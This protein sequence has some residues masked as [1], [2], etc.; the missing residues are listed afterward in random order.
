MVATFIDSFLAPTFFADSPGLYW[1]PFQLR[2][3]SLPRM[4]NTPSSPSTYF[5]RFSE[6]DGHMFF[7]LNCLKFALPS[8]GS[9]IYFSPR[10]VSTERL[11]DLSP[12]NS[13]DTIFGSVSV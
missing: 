2:Q 12:S 7:S 13:L 9:L 6:D 8:R 4:T 11:K 5:F 3:F 10:L 1:M